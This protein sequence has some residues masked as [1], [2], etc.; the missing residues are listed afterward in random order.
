MASNAA[1]P[2][3]ID[4]KGW[5]TANVA[6]FD[7]VNAN[8]VSQGK[9]PKT[10]ASMKGDLQTSGTWGAW[11]V[12]AGGDGQ[13]VRMN[14]AIA[15]GKAANPGGETL[16]PQ[17]KSGLAFSNGNLT[18]AWNATSGSW[19]S[20]FGRHGRTSGK[21]YF[22][23]TAEVGNAASFVGLAPKGA[24]ADTFYKDTGT[25]AYESDGTL[26]DDGAKGAT[27]AKWRSAGDTVGLAVDF[28]AGKIW[29]RGPD[30]TWQGTNADPG[31]GTGP[32]FTFA[33]GTELFPAVA[34]GNKDRLTVNFGATPFKTMHP[35]GFGKWPGDEVDLTGGAVSVDVTLKKVP[36]TGKEQMLVVNDQDINMMP[37]VS[38]DGVSL[39]SN[40]AKSVLDQ[41]EDSFDDWFQANIAKF[42]NDFHKVDFDD[43]LAKKDKFEWVKTTDM[44]YAVKDAA[45]AT[46][47]TSL[48]AILSMTENRSDANL[49]AEV[50][51]EMLDG[52][53]AGTNVVFAIAAERFTRKILLAGAQAMM[54]GSKETDFEI[55]Q[56]GTTVTNT[57]KLKW[58][59]LKLAD[60]TE[61]EPVVDP[62]GM[63]V[64]IDKGA[65]KFSFVNMNFDYPG[66]K[67]PGKETI[68]F[69]FDQY[70]HLH[71]EK[72]SD[73]RHVIA[74]KNEPV[75]D[76]KAT[77]SPDIRNFKVVTTLDKAARDFEFWMSV[78]ALS[79]TVFT[80]GFGA[81]S[82][83]GGVVKWVIT[84]AAVDAEAAVNVNNASVNA[85]GQTSLNAAL[86]DGEDAADIPLQRYVAANGNI[87]GPG[88]ALLA[89]ANGDAVAA[90]DGGVNGAVATAN[91]GCAGFIA[92]NAVIYATGG[93]SATAFLGAVGTWTTYGIAKSKHLTAGDVDQIDVSQTVEAF[94]EQ[95]L[96]QFD[97]PSTTQREL[98]DVHLAK[99]F[100]LY[101]KY[102]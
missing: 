64:S 99:S 15:D 22:E 74:P 47:A 53:P 61:V 52:A 24:D 10:F 73:G 70:V 4:L 86:I 23:L 42:D 55:D 57:V 35:T 97:W 94:L 69:T 2:E 18:V 21:Y 91:G 62:G 84:D 9:V 95:I 83:V 72:R 87:Y 98:L 80:V 71:L 29:V 56:L 19:A 39:P 30:G 88:P 89:A 77:G 66:W 51:S 41:I 3:E 58:Q 75:G 40:P 67:L 60:G 33:P 102:S 27:V 44:T 63:T 81:T 8:I 49:G 68:G 76:A 16:N 32:S 25:Y 31:N 92:K 90:V 28:D 26:Q 50:V 34:V 85:Y 101:L 46:T 12:V 14:C 93:I 100:L 79:L 82:I 38:I 45:A 78:V 11:T 96:E 43:T 5:D 54:A 6:T 59:K 1:R 36:G 7:V 17:Q 13:T 20:V 48:F 65:I 37:A